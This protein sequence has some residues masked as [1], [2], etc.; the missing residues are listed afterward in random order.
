MFLTHF[1]M[2]IPAVFAVIFGGV[3]GCKDY[4]TM[5]HAEGE[6]FYSSDDKGAGKGDSY[7]KPSFSGSMLNSWGGVVL[8]VNFHGR[9]RSIGCSVREKQIV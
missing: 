6:L 5:P 8:F 9:A 7:W 4:K 3:F 1:E 2:Q